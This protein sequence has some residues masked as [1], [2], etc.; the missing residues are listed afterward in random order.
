M[1]KILLVGG[2]QLSDSFRRFPIISKEGLKKAFLDGPQN[3][4]PEKV[5]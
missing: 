2:K 4:V 1:R 3:N 5:R